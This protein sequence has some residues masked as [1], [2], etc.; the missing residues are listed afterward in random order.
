MKLVRFFAVF[1]LIAGIS[2]AQDTGQE[3][4]IFK[5]AID[6]DGIQRAEITG[7]EYFFEPYHII[8]KINMPVELTVRKKPGIVPHDII[9]NAPEA[10]INFKE[11]LSKEPKVIK[12][13]PKKT[14]KYPVYCSKKLL[15]FKSHRE[16]GM[17]GLLEVIE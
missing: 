5:V 8:V 4:K 14:G 17:E 6:K 11:D 15:F 12:F 1:L 3:K 10:G 2:F 16:R 7:G 9:V 13:T